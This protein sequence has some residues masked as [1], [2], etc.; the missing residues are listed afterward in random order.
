MYHHHYCYLFGRLQVL[1]LDPAKQGAPTQALLPEGAALPGPAS[2]ADNPRSFESISFESENGDTVQGWLAL[3]AE[4]TAGP[5]RTILHTHGGP[6]SIQMQSYNPAAQA[7]LDAGFAWCSINYHGSTDFGKEWCARRRRRCR[8]RCHRC[9]CFCFY[10]RRCLDWADLLT[11]L[12]CCTAPAGTQGA[13]D[14]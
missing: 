5:F 7:W 3:P 9:G 12:V 2:S 4:E 14:M 13:V 6:S 1:S 10:S 11:G 8:R